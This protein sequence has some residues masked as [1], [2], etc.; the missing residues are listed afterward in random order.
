M[1]ELAIGIDLGGTKIA[2]G[3]FSPAGALRGELAVLPTA[4]AGPAA[5][6]LDNLFRAVEKALASASV[7]AGEL[8]GI[9]LGTTGPLDPWRK[10]LLEAEAL[11]RL[12]HVPLGR[13]LEDRF[14]K[15]LTLTNDGNC[16]A[17]A[18]A[19]FGA[20]RGEEIVLGVTLGTGCGVGVVIRG[21]FL[22]GA[23]ANTGEVYRARVGDLTFDEALSGRGL[24]RLYRQR[25][26]DERPGDEI[27][28]LAQRGDERARQAFEDFGRLAAEGLGTLAAV[29]DPGVIVLGGSV[30]RAHDHF[31]EVLEREIARYLAPS[32]AERL[33]IEVSQQGELAGPRGAAAL[34]FSGGRLA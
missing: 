1:S 10:T 12:H 14:G 3:V 21:R 24:E 2:A 6:T 8:R 30:A 22:E 13:L 5:G 23:S 9:G 7:A 31:R 28:R 18:E 33:R 19:L 20:G 17:L 16:F 27:H 4:A 11:P 25:G 26:G 34:V 32:A 15:P 29:L